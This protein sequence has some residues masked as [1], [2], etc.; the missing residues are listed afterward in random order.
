MKQQALTLLALAS[1]P[2]IND[3]DAP[4]SERVKQKGNPNTKLTNKQKKQRAKN[5]IAKKSR[6]INRK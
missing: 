6:K 5:K 4:L 3:Y 2:I 1:L